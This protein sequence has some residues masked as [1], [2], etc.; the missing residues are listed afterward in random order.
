MV[1]VA[2]LL[3]FYYQKKQDNH[4]P[5]N[6]SNTSYINND[7]PTEEQTRTGEN[8]KKD[9]LDRPS[10]YQD[11][12]TTNSA[13][14]DK[15]LTSMTIT[16]VN[17]SVDGTLRIRTMIQDTD[18]KGECKLRLEGNEDNVIDITVPTQVFGTYTVCKGFDIPRAQLTA[19]KTTIVVTYSGTHKTATAQQDM[20]IR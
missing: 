9:A 12:S 20:E 4:T 17:Q 16:S 13:N 5:N 3:W 11:G 14:N 10:P 6:S 7:K 1:I 18:D 15:V 2:T 19:G 8:I